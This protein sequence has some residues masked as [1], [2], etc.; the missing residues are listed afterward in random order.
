VAL[1]TVDRQAVSR[2]FKCTPTPVPVFVSVIWRSYSA[3]G[4]DFSA[5]NWEMQF[6]KSQTASFF[7]QEQP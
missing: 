7:I 6:G 1:P 4:A 3:V 2:V 5:V